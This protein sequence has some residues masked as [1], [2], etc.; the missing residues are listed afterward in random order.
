MSVVMAS[1]NCEKYVGDA[2]ESIL[3]QTFKDFEF[4]ILDDA[5]RD[6]TY[7][8]IKTYAK[9]DKRIRLYKNK[10]NMQVAHSL[11]KG[12]TLAKTDIIVR[13]DADDVSYPKRLETQYK[14]LLRHKNVAVV[15]SNM[16]IMNKDGKIVSKREYSSSSKE[17]K[18]I[19]F[20]YSPFAHPSVVF[21]KHVFEEFGGYDPAMVPCE[22]IDLWFKIGSKYEFGNIPK[23]LL[24][25]RFIISSNSHKGLK[26]LELLGLKIKLNAIRKYGYKISFD[27]IIFNIMQ[28]LSLW[29]MPNRER[30]YFYDFLRSRKLI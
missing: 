29:F 9:K 22:D 28:Y 4:I 2:I 30:I 27:D 23:T 21:R 6:N 25:Y 14:Y 12:V 20:R 16:D 18:K 19:S 3:N 5:S 11:N 15:G 8:V 10:K 17:L 1:Y 7:S 24:K 26:K 13:M